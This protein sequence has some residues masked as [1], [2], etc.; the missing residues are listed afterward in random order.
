[1]VLSH[2]HMEY[3]L[4]QLFNVYAESVKTLDLIN[5]TLLDLAFHQT[6][7]QQSRHL[8]KCVMYEQYKIEV[9]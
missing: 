2:K 6:K 1:M 4:K 5:S 9:K 8:A 7:C 3:S